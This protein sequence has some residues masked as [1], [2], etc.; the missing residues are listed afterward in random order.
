MA[1][2]VRPGPGPVHDRRMIIRPPRCARSRCAGQRNGARRWPRPDSG[3]YAE[4]GNDGKRRYT[5]AEIAGAF[6]V[7]RKTI[8]R[9]LD[10]NGAQRQPGKEHAVS[11]LPR[12]PAPHGAR[13]PRGARTS[14]GYGLPP[15]AAGGWWAGRWEMV[16]TR[17]VRAGGAIPGFVMSPRRACSQTGPGLV[18]ARRGCCAG[19]GW[20]LRVRRWALVLGA[21]GR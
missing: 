8:Y 19:A 11:H 18:S 9:H 16:S 6:A 17:V 15:A 4:T 12:F 13:A 3:M 1:C 7:S 10:K 21:W 2:Q 20:W 5:V 14:T